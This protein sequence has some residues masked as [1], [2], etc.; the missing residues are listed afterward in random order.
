[1]NIRHGDL[2]VARWF[3]STA[4]E[5]CLLHP[6]LSIRRSGGFALTR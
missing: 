3:T 2:L 6:T 1:M 4:R 5:L